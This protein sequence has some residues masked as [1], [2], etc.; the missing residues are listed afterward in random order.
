MEAYR[1]IDYCS[2]RYCSMH[3]SSFDGRR[4]SATADIPLSEVPEV[5]GAEGVGPGCY[6]SLPKHA[7][8][9]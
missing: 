2:Y 9:E 7:G 8:F 4:M 1:D 6:G 3:G 5:S